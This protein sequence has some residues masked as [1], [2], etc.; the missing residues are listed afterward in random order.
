MGRVNDMTIE[1]EQDKI[2]EEEET[3]MSDYEEKPI[4]T[5]IQF[6]LNF[7]VMLLNAGRV[8]MAEESLAKANALIEG[9][10]ITE[11]EGQ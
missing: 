9:A 3:F 1:I 5:R 8:D 6:H 4:K 10:I 11:G 7:M 2:T